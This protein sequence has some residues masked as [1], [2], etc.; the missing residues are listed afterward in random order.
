MS[1]DVE[2]TSVLSM[3]FGASDLSTSVHLGESACDLISNFICYHRMV[4]IIAEIFT[5]PFNI[6]VS[7]NER[8]ICL[9]SE[10]TRVIVV[11]Q[12]LC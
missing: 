8:G 2:L 5:A 10:T 1:L 9:G 3:Q 12:F 11:I 4:E 6:R 7:N